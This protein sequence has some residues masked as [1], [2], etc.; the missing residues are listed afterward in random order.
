[1][2]VSC[3][4]YCI[5]MHGPATGTQL[6]TC[7]QSDFSRFGSYIGNLARPFGEPMTGSLAAQHHT[8]AYAPRPT[9]TDAR[10]VPEG[11]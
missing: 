7:L 5:I 8:T 10:C 9:V 1:M 6:V 2:V 4:S 11:T 3:C